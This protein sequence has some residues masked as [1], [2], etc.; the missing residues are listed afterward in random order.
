MFIQIFL[1]YFI[2]KY[3]KKLGKLLDIY[4]R[5]LIYKYYIIFSL[6][7]IKFSIGF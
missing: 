5:F 4:I 7:L 1:M 2:Y 6:F 3:K